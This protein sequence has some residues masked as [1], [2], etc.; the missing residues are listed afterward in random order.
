QRI[1]RV[2]VQFWLQLPDAFALVL[3]FVIELLALGK[4]FRPR[5]IVVVEPDLALTRDFLKL[6]GVLC[7]YPMRLPYSR[8]AIV[9][10][11]TP[12]T[13]RMPIGRATSRRVAPLSSTSRIIS[14]T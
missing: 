13:A 3:R 6:R 12:T 4:A 10:A 9:N 1:A 2:R 11:T 14:T 5:R 7:H 8:M